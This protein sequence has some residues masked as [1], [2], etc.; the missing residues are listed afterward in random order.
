MRILITTPLYPPDIAGAAPYVKELARRLQD[1]HTVT[2]L[3]YNHIPES[4]ENVRIIS[5]EKSAPL[6]IRLS[7]FLA[8]LLRE[9]GSAD[10]VL[11]E[12]GPSV[13]LPLFF[14]RLMK[15]VK[16]VFH[17]ADVVALRHAKQSLWYHLPFLLAEWSSDLVIAYEENAKKGKQHVF[18]PQPLPRPEI[19]PFEPRPTESLAAYEASWKS[20]TEEIIRLFSRL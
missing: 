7:Q 14:A 15:K 10:V 8:A 9:M 17:T 12:N 3:A 13:E 11:V 6:L 2:I 4:I 5:I 1:R 18:L 16:V 20:H 19:L